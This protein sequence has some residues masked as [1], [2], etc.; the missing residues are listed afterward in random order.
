MNC[1]RC[2][3]P[4]TERQMRDLVEEHR[5][6][7][8]S[9]VPADHARRGI[10]LFLVMSL[11]AALV[12]LGVGLHFNLRDLLRVR[13][14]SIPGA[15]GQSIFATLLGVLLGLALAWPL[16]MGTGDQRLVGGEIKNHA[17]PSLRSASSR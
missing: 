17:S 12:G 14:V 10:A 3:K 13:N 11:L 2:G 4:I 6:F 5:A 7:Q 9:L 16:K 15:V 1:Q 8:K